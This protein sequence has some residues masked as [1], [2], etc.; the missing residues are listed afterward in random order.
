MDRVDQLEEENDVLGS[1]ARYTEERLE[2][3]TKQITAMD[4]EIT[5][6]K[7]ALTENEKVVSD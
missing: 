5:K 1:S 3:K 2:I 6:L 4:E 7:G